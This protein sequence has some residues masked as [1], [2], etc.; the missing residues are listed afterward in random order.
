MSLKK[1]NK[2]NFHKHTFC[3]FVEVDATAI[4]TID[5]Q[6]KSKSGSS[7][8]FTDEGVYRSS[9]HWGRAANCRWRLISEI[10]NPNQKERVGY[11]KWTDFYPNNETENFFYVEV[12]FE[13][14]EVT[15]QHKNNPK[16]DGKAVLRNAA[17]TAKVIRQIKEIL[18]S[19]A[20]AKYL[21]YDD[22]EV[23]RKEIITDYLTTNKKF[24]ELKKRFF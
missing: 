4:L 13:T 18:E 14:K 6:Y 11:A 20:W 19:D 16:Y 24:I 15:F 8:C 23:L 9:N 21:D 2:T 1:Y 17:E 5:W 7:Y 22:L 10:K 12:N 3:E